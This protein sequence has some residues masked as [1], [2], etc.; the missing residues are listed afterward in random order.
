MH[1]TVLSFRLLIVV[2]MM[3]IVTRGFAQLS[4]EQRLQ[5]SVIGWDPSNVY[6]HWKAPTDAA[7]R[8]KE[9]YLDKMVEWIKRSYTPVGGMGEYQRYTNATGCQVLFSVWDVDFEH[10]NAQKRFRPL[11]ETGRPMFYMSINSLAGAWNIDFLCKPDSWYFTM[12]A[13]GYSPTDYETK[14]RAGSDPRI[15]VLAHP[16][17][18]WVNEWYTVYLAPGNKLPM[19]RVTKGELLQ[20]ALRNLDAVEDSLVRE[21]RERRVTGTEGSRKKE[22][23]GYRANIR[24][25]LDK[26]K[27]VLDEPASVTNW[28]FSFRDFRAGSLDLFGGG[29]NTVYHPVYK[30]DAATIARMKAGQPLWVTIMFP[31]ATPTDGNKRYEAFAALTQHVNYEYIYNYFFDTAKVRG[32]EYAPADE[33][34]LKQRLDA[35][36]QRNAANLTAKADTR[37]W[38]ADVHFQEDFG[39]AADGGEPVNWFFSRYAEL[40]KVV[41]LEG[42]AG[43]WLKLGYSNNSTPVLMK[44]PLPADFLLE[45]DLVTSAFTGRYGGGARLYLSTNKATPN[46][47]EQTSAYAAKIGLDITAGNE[48]DYTNN[49]YSGVARMELLRIPEVN[50]QN[51]AKGAKLEY[52]LRQFTDRKR[53]I[54]VGLEVNKGSFR[55]L[56]DGSPVMASKDMLL[57]YGGKCADC[58]VP[59][60]LR[61]NYL[62]WRGNQSGI[63]AYI[64]NIKITRK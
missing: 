28:Q 59:A 52:P 12:Q 57:T 5:D 54:H 30:I 9:R 62:Y 4:P 41:T 16:W 36:R 17:L 13:D 14:H 61:F 48:N 25:L 24:L 26:Y 47:G 23:D 42:Y 11:S 53:M 20:T 7:G 51:F 63:P 10:L 33:A 46:G 3:F 39:S 40:D 43:K 37:N 31:F 35:F 15:S 50:E 56:V 19:V 38:A 22:V 45:F 44:K 49:N 1:D 6:D 29:P 55:M 8:Q 27:H 18:T 58:S 64:G 2:A 60:D 34:G 32:K 21:D